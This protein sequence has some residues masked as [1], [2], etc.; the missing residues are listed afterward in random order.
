MPPKRHPNKVTEYAGIDYVRSTVHRCGCLYHHIDGN[1]DYGNDCF[2]ELFT[3]DV[4]TSFTIAVQVKSGPS[5]RTAAGYAIPAR[6][7]QMEYWHNFHMPVAGIVYDMEQECAYWVDISAYL[8]AHPQVIEQNSHSIPVSHANPFS[9]NAFIA[10]K[11]HFVSIIQEYKDFENFGRSLE[12]FADFSDKQRCFG[13]MKSLFSNHRDR[14]AAWLYLITSFEHITSQRIQQDILGMLSNF[15]DNPDIFWNSEEPMYKLYQASDTRQIVIGYIERNFSPGAV[16]QA[17]KF[18]S[19]GINRGSFSYRV[20]LILRRVKNVS[21]VILGMAKKSKI[22]PED[23]H[24]L[25]WLYIHFAQYDPMQQVL[26]EILHYLNE[27]P[28]DD[29]AEMFIGMREII[30]TEGFIQTG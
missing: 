9:K 16:K 7:T 27:F 17:I 3:N 2:I 1:D 6:K 28:E 19:E 12:A 26:A 21:E 30:K 5:Y 13:G 4:A 25:F 15:L 8:R 10:F 14:T 22:S 23:R 20:F 18:L 11:D 29:D 24:F